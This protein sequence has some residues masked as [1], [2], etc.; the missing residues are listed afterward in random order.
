MTDENLLDKISNLQK[1]IVELKKEIFERLENIESI[2]ESDELDDTENNVEPY[3]RLRKYSYEAMNQIKKELTKAL[4][5]GNKNEINQAAEKAKEIIKITEDV[6]KQIEK[7][8]EQDEKRIEVDNPL[9]PPKKLL[10]Y[11]PATFRPKLHSRGATKWLGFLLT[12]VGVVIFSRG[13]WEGAGEVFSI[14]GSLIIG[15]AIIILMAWLER[16]KIFSVFEGG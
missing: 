2:S 9:Y 10:G 8:K 4:E 14:Q 16:K 13:V 11:L 15:A 6:I 7:I 12:G 1:Q 5:K 3:K